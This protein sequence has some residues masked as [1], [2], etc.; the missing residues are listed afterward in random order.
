MSYHWP[1]VISCHKQAVMST[2]K[3]GKW[4]TQW[5]NQFWDRQ[6]DGQTEWKCRC[7]A[8]SLQLKSFPKYVTKWG[9]PSLNGRHGP[10]FWRNQKMSAPIRKRIACRLFWALK[11]LKKVIPSLS[12]GRSKFGPKS[13]HFLPHFYTSSS[14]FL[15]FTVF[16]SIVYFFGHFLSNPPLKNPRLRPTQ[17]TDLRLGFS[18]GGYN[19][20]NHDFLF[21]NPSPL[22]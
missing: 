18:R 2:R 19:F 1:A 14:I 13:E 11:F 16:T 6:T 15:A 10:N 12:Y 5:E 7:W 20:E 8:A 21:L 4:T 17:T 3:Q 22:V 9:V